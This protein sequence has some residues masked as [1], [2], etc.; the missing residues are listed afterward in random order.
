MRMSKLEEFDERRRASYAARRAA[1][2]SFEPTVRSF[3]FPNR[4]RGDCWRVEDIEDKV[5]FVDVDESVVVSGM[6]GGDV[7]GA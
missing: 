5:V 2:S 7:V 4:V 3:S 1:R 6:I